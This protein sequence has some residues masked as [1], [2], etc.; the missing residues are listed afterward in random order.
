MHISLTNSLH[1]QVTVLSALLHFSDVSIR[2][3]TDLDAYETNLEKAQCFSK[4][5]ERCV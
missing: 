5:G 4:V 1:L 3:L 2:V